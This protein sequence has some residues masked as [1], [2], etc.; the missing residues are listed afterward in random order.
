M[1][2]KKVVLITGAA[3]KL[4]QSLSKA[5][6]E[7]NGSVIMVDIDEKRLNKLLEKLPSERVLGYSCDASNKKGIYRQL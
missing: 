7:N 5:I 3:G 1:I 6:L 2:D 4:G